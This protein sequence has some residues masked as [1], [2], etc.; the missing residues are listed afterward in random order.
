MSPLPVDG[1]AESD[2]N[3]AGPQHSRFTPTAHPRS[4]SEAAD[5]EYHLK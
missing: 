2:P 5:G 1:D 3:I 4:A